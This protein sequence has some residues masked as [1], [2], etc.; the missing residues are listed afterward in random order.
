MFI[1]H[2]SEQQRSRQHRLRCKP[3]A[4]FV[5]SLRGLSTSALCARRNVQSSPKAVGNLAGAPESHEAV[6]RGLSLRCCASP[7]YCLRNGKIA[8]L[9]RFDNLVW[10]RSLPDTVESLRRKY[11][12]ET[13]NTRPVAVGISLQVHLSSKSYSSIQLFS[14]GE[15]YFSR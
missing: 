6:G 4:N 9:V 5:N 14:E 13:S 12:V 1:L 11:K 3:K 7:P 2:S 10:S 15:Y 8:K